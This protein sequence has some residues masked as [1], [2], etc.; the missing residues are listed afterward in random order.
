M[1]GFGRWLGVFSLSVVFSV[2]CGLGTAERSG[3]QA[4]PTA[5]RAAY[6]L[7]NRGWV[8]DAIAAFQRVLRQSPNS[9]DA[10][11]G[12]AMAYQRAGQDAAAWT[13]YQQV[14]AQDGDN[15]AALTAIG[16]L[17]SYRAEWQAGGITALTQLLQLT[18]NDGAAR[19][20]RALLLGYQGR[21]AESFVDYQV[22]LANNPAPA[23]LLGAAQVYSYS[24]DYGRSLTLFD[25][26]RATGRAIPDGALTAY[27]RTV[28][29]TGEPATAIQLLEAKLRQ[30]RVPDW[31]VPDLRGTLAVAYQANQQPQQALQVLAPLRQQPAHSIVLARALHTMGRRSGDAQLRQQAADLYRQALRQTPNPSLGLQV[32]AADA[33]SELA[34]GRADA[35]T[36]Y[37]QLSQQQ[38]GDR[39]L[40]VK[41]LVLERQL[42]SLSPTALQQQL[43]ATLQPL[44]DS[45]IEQQAVAIALTQ[46]D[47]PLADLLPIYQEL[48]Q[49][50][51]DAPFLN[52]RVAQIY[53]QQGNLAEA[54][55]ALAAYQATSFGQR[56]LGAELML[57]E[58]DRRDSNLDNSA[59]RYEAV[60]AQNPAVSIQQD[61]L[62]GLA[63]VRREQGKLAE[64]V[65]FYQALL[66]REPDNARSQIGYL[67]LR[68]QLKQISDATAIQELD[69]WLSQQSPLPAYPE[70]LTL[71]G[72]LPADPER[73]PLYMSLLELAPA[74]LAVERRLIQVIA[75]RDLEAARSRME[76][77]VAGDRGSIA[78]YFVQGELAQA[79]GDLALADQSYASIL[80]QQ[81]DN[82]DALSALAG[83]KFQQKQYDAA[84]VLYR[85]VLALKPNDLETQRVLAE[86]YLA[87]DLPQRG[88]RQLQQVQQAQA[89]QG[90]TN[91]VVGD[92][93]QEVEL[94]FLRR[95]GLQPYWE[96]Y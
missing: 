38:P 13:A 67:N 71:V 95:R 65:P 68:Y 12:L 10:K 74:N 18:P 84:A 52:I 63:T 89:A 87:Q 90:I 22:L 33:L 17:G 80:Q 55:Q 7:L 2:A 66:A 88:L 92:R 32:E 51:V 8:N 53:L 79:L 23:A 94:N 28:A 75:Q 21:Y 34:S 30:P 58:V 82:T 64:V 86:L 57:A 91:P 47:P 69:Q 44:P 50:E 19:T 41:R 43:Q 14:L 16:L 96:R 93:V 72:A 85:R 26:Y 70:L 59:Q 27:A 1:K 48:L 49:S 9:L 36:I 54:R 62:L 42:G 60:I 31:L 45:V 5:V 3:A 40:I 20:Q 11:L 25:R 37:Q 76:Q 29:E 78:G 73:E 83:V 39:S 46:L 61:A 56:D 4:Q 6:T 15:R 24:G 81:P 77:V 35:L